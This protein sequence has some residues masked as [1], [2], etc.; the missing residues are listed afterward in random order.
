[1]RAK[2]RARTAKYTVERPLHCGATL[3]DA[4]ADL[5]TALS[6]Y[7]LPLGEAFPARRPVPPA[8]PGG[9]SP[10]PSRT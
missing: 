10:R 1:M 2:A 5:H 7:A 9:P 4:E 8:L 6:F 3:A